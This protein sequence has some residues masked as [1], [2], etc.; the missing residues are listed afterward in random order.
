[1]QVPCEP[2]TSHASQLPAHGLSQQKP[3][4]QLPL[5]HWVLAVHAEPLTIVP[6]E[7]LTQGAPTHWGL[8][9]H[10]FAQVVPPSVHVKGAQVTGVSATQFPLPSHAAPLVALFVVGSQDGPPQVVPLGQTAQLPLPS[11]VPFCPQVP[12][13]VA[14][15]AARGAGPMSPA[16]TGEHVPF[17]APWLHWT[18]L[19]SHG[20]SQQTPSTQCLLPHSPAS[21]HVAPSESSAA[22]LL[23]SAAASLASIPVASTASIGSASPPSPAISASEA[24]S[25]AVVPSASASIP[26]TCDGNWAQPGAAQRTMNGAATHTATT[27][28][29]IYGVPTVGRLLTEGRRFNQDSSPTCSA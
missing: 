5:V 12:A 18:Q 29:D 1:V 14:V 6:Q 28:A 21:E 13:S 2:A 24:A 20:V 27:A 11:H 16:S 17:S 7:L 4:T 9:E 22:S 25:E 8:E 10:D 26:D 15:H 3:S 23:T 19:P